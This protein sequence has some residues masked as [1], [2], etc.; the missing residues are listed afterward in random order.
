[1]IAV[2][3]GEFLVKRLFTAGGV[4]YLVPINL[5]FRRIELRDGDQVEI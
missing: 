3:G 5:A 2:I 4:K 1:V